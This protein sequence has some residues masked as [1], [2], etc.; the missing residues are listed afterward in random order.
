[1]RAGHEGPAAQVDI[2]GGHRETV[3]LSL[4]PSARRRLQHDHA[5]SLRVHATS[6]LTVGLP[7]RT[8]KRIEA[9]TR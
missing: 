1:V 7:T 9:R 4:A 3:R 6:Q 2:A 8:S 5:V